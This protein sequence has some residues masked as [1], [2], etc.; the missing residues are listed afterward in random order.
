MNERRRRVGG[1][2]LAAQLTRA[3]TGG[4]GSRCP[5]WLLMLPCTL[6]TSE[7]TPSC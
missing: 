7:C 2:R 5:A 6:V 4:Q 1:G 3:G